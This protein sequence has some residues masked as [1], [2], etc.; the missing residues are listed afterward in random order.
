V[1]A[2]ASEDERATL[3]RRRAK[4][5]EAEAEDRVEQSVVFDKRIVEIPDDGI[6]MSRPR[7]PTRSCR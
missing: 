2:Y 1:L 7:R 3:R 5:L 6:P 4:L